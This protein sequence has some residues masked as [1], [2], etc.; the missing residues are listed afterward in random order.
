[1]TIGRV[2][3]MSWAE[4][5]VGFTCVETVLSV[6]S[7]L[8][9]FVSVASWRLT[10]SVASDGWSGEAAA[11]SGQPRSARGLRSAPTADFLPDTPAGL[12]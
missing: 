4:R 3:L 2:R 1:M 12:R 7:G 11:Y 6:G 8:G 10:A 9:G 5:G